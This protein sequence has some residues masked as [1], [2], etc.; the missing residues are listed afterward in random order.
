MGPAAFFESNPMIPQSFIQG[1]R[2]LVNSSHVQLALVA[3][4]PA[5]VAAR[6]AASTLPPEQRA[7]LWIACAVAA[8]VVVREVINSLTEENVA[9][10]AASTPA[11]DPAVTAQVQTN[12]GNIAKLATVLNA[13][14]QKIATPSVHDVSID[15]LGALHLNAWQREQVVAWQKQDAAAAINVPPR[16]NL[17]GMK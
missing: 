6:Y 8:G 17:P 10:I 11:A 12:A 16:T 15:P 4:G 5:F 3:A 9:A 14:T 1:V 13:T 2:R 7:N